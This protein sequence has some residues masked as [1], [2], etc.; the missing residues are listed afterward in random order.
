MDNSK[1]RRIV[2]GVKT[3]LIVLLSCSALWLA[4]QTPLAAPMWG[5][6]R[7]EGPQV[8][9]GQSQGEEHGPGGVPMAMA[10]NLFG[11]PDGLSLPRARCHS[12]RLPSELR[13]PPSL[14]GLRFL[15]C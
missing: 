7:E 15:S 5:L 12:L 11:A 3:I 1:I 2:E 10:V 8:Q 9:P 14:P 6:L 4:A 13:Y